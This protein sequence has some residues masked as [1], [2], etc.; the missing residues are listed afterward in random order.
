MT[1]AST[2]ADLCVWG[3]GLQNA[4][5]QC[6]G[7]YVVDIM[8]DFDLT[9]SDG[10]KDLAGLAI[11]HLA[12]NLTPTS[13]DAKELWQISQCLKK[14]RYGCTATPEEIA[15]GWIQRNAACAEPFRG[16][17]WVI[18]GMRRLLAPLEESFAS[19]S[20]DGRFGDGHVYEGVPPFAR[21]NYLARALPYSLRCPDDIRWWNS[22][23]SRL[24]ARLQ[25]VPK[26]MFKLRSITV[27]PTEATF[28]QHWTRERLLQAIRVIPRNSAIPD[29]AWGGG[30]ERQRSRCLRASSNARLATIDLSDASDSV[31]WDVVSAVFP[32]NVVAELE[33]ARSPYCEVDGTRYRV[34]MFAGMGNATTFVVESLYFWALFTTV[35]RWLRDLTPVSVFGDDIILSTRVARHPLFNEIVTSC[36]IRVNM[37]K[38]GMSDVPG[39]REACGCAAYCGEKLPLL[40][41]KGYDISKPDELVSLCTLYNDVLGDTSSLYAPFLKEGLLAI[42]G[43]LMDLRLPVLPVRALAAGAYIA[44][45]SERIGEWSYRS[46]WNPETQHPEVKV[47]TLCTRDKTLTVDNLTPGECLGV[48]RGQLHTRFKDAPVGYHSRR[49]QFSIPVEDSVMLKSAWTPV[50]SAYEGLFCDLLQD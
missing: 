39:F 24:S 10:V 26:D 29:Q 4:V 32:A 43:P 1:E 30:P 40:R 37:D 25:C 38:S 28:L 44:D 9:K 35:S 11:R 49:T 16:P 19:S 14:F 42:S 13:M 7:G 45:P 48:L 22:D 27:E 20:S 36:G 46:R 8:R 34:H 50:W 15:E 17:W 23:N 21:W 31:R 47:R 41:I 12:N 33:R 6:G 18:D 2:Y 5:S 3:R